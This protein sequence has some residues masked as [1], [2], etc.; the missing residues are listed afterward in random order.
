MRGD[1]ADAAR[2][3]VQRDPVARRYRELRWSRYQAVSPLSIIAALSVGMPG[4]KHT[5]QRASTRSV[6]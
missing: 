2:R 1:R 4:G 6:E 5:S 3:G